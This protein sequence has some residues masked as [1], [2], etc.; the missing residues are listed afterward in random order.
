MIYQGEIDAARVINA[1][2]AKSKKISLE[3]FDMLKKSGNKSAD[4]E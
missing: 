4:I 3:F 2:P 1:G